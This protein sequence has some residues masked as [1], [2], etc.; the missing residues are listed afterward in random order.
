MASGAAVFARITDPHKVL[1]P[2]LCSARDT[3]DRHLGMV[4]VPPAL[5]F[6]GRDIIRDWLWDNGQI[7]L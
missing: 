6:Q 5:I 1:I 7:A 2:V 4:H 3:R